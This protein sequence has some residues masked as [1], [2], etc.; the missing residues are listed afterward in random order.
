MWLLSF[1]LF[2]ITPFYKK[3]SAKWWTIPGVFCG[4]RLKDVRMRCIL[5]DEKNY[6]AARGISDPPKETISMI[7]DHIDRIDL[8][9]FG[10]AAAKAFEF[11]KTLTPDTPDATCEIIGRD[12]YAMVQ[13]YDTEADPPPILE[14]HRKYIDIQYCI[15]GAEYI[16]VAPLDESTV[17]TPYDEAKDVAFYH[18]Q[19]MMSLCAMTPGRFVLLFPTDEHFA[20]YAA[21]APCRIKKAVVKLRADLLY[22]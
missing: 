12:V 2:K 4:F 11:L 3:S 8:Y 1:V 7:H 14:A 15:A 13:S 21:E 19:K 10:Q 16:A 20:K 6:A 17:K 18:A 9:R 5:E 22:K